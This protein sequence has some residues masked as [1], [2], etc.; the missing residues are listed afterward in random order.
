MTFP[1][2]NKV[3]TVQLGAGATSN[4]ELSG[5]AE[6]F[7]KYLES[8]KA[9]PGSMRKRRDSIRKLLLYMERTG[10]QRF[11]D[12]D[13]KYIE[14]Y[15]LCLVEHEYSPNTIES[16]IR[17]VLLFFKFLED[18]NIIFDNPANRIKI[19]KTPVVIGTVLTEEE[20]QKVLA[21]PDITKP[22][23]L[24]DRAILEVLY[25]TGMRREEVTNL[26]IYDIDLERATVKVTGKFRKQRIIPLG[27][28]AVKY[29][30]LYLTEARPK[31]LPKF[32]PA[33]D[34]LWLTFER[35]RMNHVSIVTLL[36]KC[37]K[38]TGINVTAHALRRT[39][40]THMLRHGAHPVVVAHMLGHAELT[41]L[42]HYLQ[43]N[44]TDLMKSHAQSNPGK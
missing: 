15:R 28:H 16:D 43:T 35:K 29:L 27:K 1:K 33:P 5:M 23:G 39:C 3:G 30:R 10:V 14:D 34:N 26:S 9:A 25:S 32:K 44:V 6:E 21:V 41:S 40:A 36:S 13:V 31:L 12:V 17:A 20:I 7:F 11:Q 19:P 24:R 18:K 38:R 37:A 22:R 42:G 2:S 4:A 8:Q